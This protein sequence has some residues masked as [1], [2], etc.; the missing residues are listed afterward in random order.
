MNDIIIIGGFVVPK[1]IKVL[2][3]ASSH[4]VLHDI[5]CIGCTDDFLQY[6]SVSVIILRAQSFRISLCY[7]EPDNCEPDS[8]LRFQAA[9]ALTT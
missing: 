2:S 5:L 4:S 6:A 1:T 7:A 3:D 9:G 8:R